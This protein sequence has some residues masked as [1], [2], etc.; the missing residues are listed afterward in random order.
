MNGKRHSLHPFRG[1]QQEVNHLLI[2]TD[3]RMVSDW[4]DET[5]VAE[6]LQVNDYEVE[7][8]NIVCN[9]WMKEK[10]NQQEISSASMALMEEAQYE[11]RKND[12]KFMAKEITKNSDVIEASRREEDQRVLT[13]NSWMKDISMSIYFMFAYVTGNFINLCADEVEPFDNL[14]SGQRKKDLESSKESEHM[15]EE[16]KDQLQ[17]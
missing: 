15:L 10:T 14:F 8:T 16:P 3:N 2:M 7:M 9:N 6:N 13:R 5:K 17:I 11:V 4:K 1:K 12:G